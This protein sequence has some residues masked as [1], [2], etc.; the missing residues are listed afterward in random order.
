MD[1][2]YVHAVEFQLDGFQSLVF[3]APD[4]PVSAYMFDGTSRISSWSPPAVYSPYPR[5][6]K[7]DLWH[8]F[9]VAGIVIPAHLTMNLEPFLSKAG[10]LLP[11]KSTN[12]DFLLLNI[13]EDI[14]CLDSFGSDLKAIP[15][16]LSFIEHRLDE[17]GLFKVPETD[18]ADIYHV[19][20]EDDEDSFRKRI[21]ALELTG[22]RFEPVWTSRQGSIE[23]TI[24]WFK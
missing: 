14:D 7:P 21:Q 11:L 4:L 1:S 24:E 12:G 20:R 13:L 5:R 23:R 8:L 17:T 22:L 6:R 19:E 18:T 2:T 3:D 9:G 10:E 15:P 16:R